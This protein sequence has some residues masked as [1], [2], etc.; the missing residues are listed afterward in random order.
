M[1]IDI[2][3]GKIYINGQMAPGSEGFEVRTKGV[4]KIRE[5]AVGLRQM[6]GG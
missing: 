3:D 1:D 2:I 6:R 4:K 5:R